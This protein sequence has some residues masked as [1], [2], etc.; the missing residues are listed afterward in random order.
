[1]LK[2]NETIVSNKNGYMLIDEREHNVSVKRKVV[3]IE[4]QKVLF[5]VSNFDY[6]EWAYIGQAYFDGLMAGIREYIP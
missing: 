6:D 1:M 3:S 4:T 2:S 5:E